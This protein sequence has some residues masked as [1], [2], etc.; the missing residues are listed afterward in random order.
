MVK[1]H[2]TLGCPL[3]RQG[4]IVRS[5]PCPAIQTLAKAISN[6]KAQEYISGQQEANTAS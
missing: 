5:S 2:G 3:A 6:I 4:V 1:R